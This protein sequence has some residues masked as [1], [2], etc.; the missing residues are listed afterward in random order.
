M[1]KSTLLF[2]LFAFFAIGVNAQ[3]PATVTFK[4]N[5]PMGLDS[6]SV[7]LFEIKIEP[8]KGWH[9]Y[10]AEASEEGA[11]KPTE[12]EYDINSRGFMADDKISETGLL[13]KEF[14]DIM[15]GMMRY[16][17]SPVTFSQRIK[18]TDAEVFLKGMVNYMACDD[19]KCLVFTEEFEIKPEK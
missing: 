7:A 19:E 5:H 18:I 6:G 17:K 15:G 11:Y 1:K 2:S 4:V 16:Y 12:I 3:T 13:M 9:V 10:S 8:N 14:D